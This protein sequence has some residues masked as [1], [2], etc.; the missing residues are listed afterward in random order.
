[1]PPPPP[2]ANRNFRAQIEIFTALTTGFSR[3]YLFVKMRTNEKRCDENLD[4]YCDICSGS[5]ESSSLCIF[6]RSK[7]H[8]TV[9]GHHFIQCH[10]PVRKYLISAFFLHLSGYSSPGQNICIFTWRQLRTSIYYR[11]LL[12]YSRV[13]NLWAIYVDVYV[14][15]AP[16][17][18]NTLILPDLVD[19]Y[20]ACTFTSDLT[21]ERHH[22]YGAL[23]G[24]LGLPFGFPG[25]PW[26]VLGQML[27]RCTWFTPSWGKYC[28]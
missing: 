2:C 20:V 26:V 21:A 13:R 25:L 10:P 19:S 28:R 14:T 1:M 6:Q 18:F 3:T 4:F 7:M 5:L 24:Y 22:F 12:D 27:L 23:W 9:E 17:I 15:S 16:L 8:V 11:F